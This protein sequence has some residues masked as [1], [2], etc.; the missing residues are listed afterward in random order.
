M[1]WVKGPVI[2][3]GSSATIYLAKSKPSNALFAVK[4][5]GAA[6]SAGLQRESA[7][8]SSIRHPCIVAHLG[9]CTTLGG[10]DE[11]TFNLFMEYMAHGTLAHLVRARAM[12]EPVIRRYAGTVLK[13]LHHLHTL[14]LVHGDIKGENILLGPN[15]L[16]K[17]GDLGC[18]KWARDGHEMAGTPLFMAPEVARGERQGQESDIWSFGCLIIEMATGLAPWLYGSSLGGLDGLSPFEAMARIGR[19][20]NGPCVPDWLSTQA[21]DFLSKCLC[22]NPEERWN[23]EQLQGH[24]FVRDVSLSSVPPSFH[25]PPSPV[26]LDFEDGV[27]TSLSPPPKEECG[28]SLSNSPKSV[29]ALELWSLSSSSSFSLSSSVK[30]RDSERGGCEAFA[31]ERLRKLAAKGKPNWERD[32]EEWITV[33]SQWNPLSQ[34]IR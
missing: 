34:W 3:R 27:S 4:S 18:A 28:V 17:I 12:T 15:G 1:E 23:A 7:I 21:K 8:L 25:A 13:G 29:L 11:P 14:G 16:A 24:G 33:K 31:S 2:G 22:L 5:M 32:E 30:E 9:S 19:A 6:R 20:K 26:S 10:N